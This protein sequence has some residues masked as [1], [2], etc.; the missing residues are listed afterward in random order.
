MKAES[1]S[2]SLAVHAAT[3][4]QLALFPWLAFASGVHAKGDIDAADVSLWRGLSNWA[5]LLNSTFDAGYKLDP[6]SFNI[7]L[8]APTNVPLNLALTLGTVLEGA[9]RFSLLRTDVTVDCNQRNSLLAG[10]C[11]ES[12]CA[13]YNMTK[14]TSEARNRTDSIVYQM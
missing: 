2:S 14:C 3:L 5:R 12:K 6:L 11:G 4:L 7:T 9:E 8:R 10:S 1:S 13:V